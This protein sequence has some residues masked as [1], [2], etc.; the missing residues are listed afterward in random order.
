MKVFVL[1]LIAIALIVLWFQIFFQRSEL[2]NVE[3]ATTFEECVALGNPVMESYPEQCRTEDGQ[4]FVRDIGNELKMSDQIRIDSPRP[5]AQISSPVTIT[6]EARGYYFFEASFPVTLVAENGDVLVESFATAGGEWMTTEFV[7]FTTTL[8]FEK[9][10]HER[11]RL[12]LKRDNPSGL[13]EN[14]ATLEVP[15]LFE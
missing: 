3:A 8:E 12:L 10:S 7:P 15:V 9:G 1:F 14:D 2:R 4:H 6:G 13:P 5:G 11:G